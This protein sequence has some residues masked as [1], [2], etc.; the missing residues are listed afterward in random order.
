M[1]EDAR[2]SHERS[3]IGKLVRPEDLYLSPDQWRERLQ[4]IDYDCCRATRDRGLLPTK[5]T[6]LCKLS[7]LLVF[8]VLWPR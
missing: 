2:D 5:N 4:Q 8:T 7:R 3:L 6:S 1:D